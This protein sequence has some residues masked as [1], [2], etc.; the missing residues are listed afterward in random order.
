MK[1]DPDSQRL[2]AYAEKREL[3]A[4][5]L[6]LSFFSS[7]AYEER[8]LGEFAIPSQ[9]KRRDTS[10]VDANTG[11]FAAV[12]LNE[13]DK[14]VVVAVRGTEFWS[15]KDWTQNFFPSLGGQADFART[16]VEKIMEEYEGWS[17]SITGHSL[18]GGLALQL[19]HELSGV[20]AIVFNPSPRIGDSRNGYGNYRVVF[21]E[22]YEPLAP[23]RGNP[24]RRDDSV[25]GWQLKYEVL[26]N[27]S[28]GYVGFRV[29]QQHSMSAMAANMMVLSK[30]WSSEAAMLYTLNCG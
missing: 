20:N 15:L 18:G 26:L 24:S 12:F 16:E 6:L 10:I 19:S 17:I 1:P 23:L 29:L 21:R 13:S 4:N 14:E 7:I 28:D 25:E 30:D 3:I 9:W 27:F 22:L 11:L 2:D 5:N 8:G